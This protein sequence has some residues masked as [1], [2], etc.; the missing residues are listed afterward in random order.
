MDAKLTRCLLAAGLPFMLVGYAAAGEPVTGAVPAMPEPANSGL[1]CA[2]PTSDVTPNVVIARLHCLLNVVDN[3]RMVEAD[4]KSQYRAEALLA[5]A[6]DADDKA[7]LGAKLG[8]VQTELR[9][10][11]DALHKAQAELKHLQHERKEGIIGK[12]NSFMG[13]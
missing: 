1:T 11:Q 9:K 12:L 7:K 5:E 8:A 4:A 3:D 2:L 6:Q 10:T 13:N